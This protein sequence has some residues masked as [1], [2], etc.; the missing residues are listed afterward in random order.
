VEKYFVGMDPN[1]VDSIV[2][3]ALEAW[4]SKGD[5]NV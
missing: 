1:K 3:Q 4:F 2:E 5:A